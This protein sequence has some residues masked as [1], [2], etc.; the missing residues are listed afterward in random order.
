LLFPTLQH[1]FCFYFYFILKNTGTATA[2]ERAKAAPI[3]FNAMTLIYEPESKLSSV[4]AIS[5][6]L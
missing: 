4:S 6:T 5:V 1:S 2:G 3:G